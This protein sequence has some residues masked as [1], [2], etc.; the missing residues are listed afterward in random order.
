MA[1]VRQTLESEVATGMTAGA[2]LVGAVTFVVYQLRSLPGRLI[3]LLERQFTVTL[4]VYGDDDVFHPLSLWLAN[5][6]AT[7]RSRRLN[8]VTKWV[9]FRRF[10]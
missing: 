1:L 8:V 4:T 2:L 7:K 6:P 9:D 3:M 10:G 5:H